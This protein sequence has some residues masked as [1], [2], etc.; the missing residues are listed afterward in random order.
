M[1]KVCVLLKLLRIPNTVPA[2]ALAPQAHAQMH[3]FKPYTDYK[4]FV[5]WVYTKIRTLDSTCRK[6]STNVLH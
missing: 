2:H 3:Y 4:G 1:Y 5:H 6:A